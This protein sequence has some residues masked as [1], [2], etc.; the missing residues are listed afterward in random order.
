MC[1]WGGGGVDK[2]LLHCPPQNDSGI[3]MGSDESHINV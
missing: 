2:I 1:V 3:K